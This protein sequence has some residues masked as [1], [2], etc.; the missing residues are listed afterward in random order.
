MA[1][2]PTLYRDFESDRSTA[3]HDSAESARPVCSPSRREFLKT[4]AVAGAGI[5][6]S[7][8]EL[9]AQNALGTP[10][11]IDVHHHM[12]PEFYVKAMGR[13]LGPSTLRS[14]TPALSLEVM[15]KAGV[16]TA[17]LSP[18][19]GVVRDSLSDR[20]DRARSL[21]RQNNEVGAQ[22]VRDHPTRFGFFAALP[23][24]D[25]DGSLREIEYP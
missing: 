18:V 5:A 11:R 23:L 24:P 15:D 16:A 8:T 3:K 9:I 22:V 14:W 4:V 19:Q 7:G 21:A 10:G 25:S 6:L 13:E 2:I 17:I 1:G 20:S 12:A